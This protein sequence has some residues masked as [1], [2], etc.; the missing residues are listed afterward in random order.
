MRASEY[1][2]IDAWYFG[3]E[4]E[5][6]EARLPT[7]EGPVTEQELNA[8]IARLTFMTHGRTG[9]DWRSGRSFIVAEKG[10]NNEFNTLR[11]VTDLLR[12][13]RSGMVSAGV[14]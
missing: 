4:K 9:R 6:R 3:I 2:D 12:R 7:G 5:L 8:V 1:D 14:S 13:V 11:E 10:G